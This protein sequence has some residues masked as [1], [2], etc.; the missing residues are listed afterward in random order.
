MGGAE[1][2]LIRIGGHAIAE[3]TAGIL[4]RLSGRVLVA[5]PRPEAWSDLPV[6]VVPDALPETG[7]L[8]GI[9]AGLEAARGGWLLVVAGD[10]PLL[11]ERL[12]RRLCARALAT[13]RAVIPRRE[14]RPEPLHAVYPAGH[15]VRARAA[16][17]AGARKAWGW[18]EEGEVEWIDLRPDEG[19][20]LAGVNTPAELRALGGSLDAS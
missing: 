12:L 3:R 1:K 15:A 4:G 17:L 18:L 6:E 20:T 10:M 7:P 2:A 9:V 16:L 14:G 5:T 11:D 19:L 13:G 8:G